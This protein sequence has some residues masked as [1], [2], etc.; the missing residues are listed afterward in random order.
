MPG[1]GRGR[2][3]G[4]G[5]FYQTFK[6]V[7]LNEETATSSNRNLKASDI[8]A[9]VDLRTI[10]SRVFLIKNYNKKNNRFT[11]FCDDVNNHLQYQ[12]ILDELELLSRA[13]K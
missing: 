10:A 6:D 1:T 5:F 13:C 3:R 11:I 7:N 2:G 4:R 9:G 8:P 12:E